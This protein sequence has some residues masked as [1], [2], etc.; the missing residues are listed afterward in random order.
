MKKVLNTAIATIAGLAAAFVPMASANANDWFYDDEDYVVERRV[1]TRHHYR[2]NDDALAAGILGLAAGAIIVGAI[3]QPRQAPAYRPRPVYQQPAY[4]VYPDAPP[5]PRRKNVV[6]YE[7]QV[8]PWT[9]DWYRFCANR[10]RS[11]NASTGTFRG[12]DGR[13]RFCVVN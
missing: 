3:T 10:Y 8:E 7:E 1:V 13:N 2:N 11:F 4:E 12:N 5:A 6:R 9:R